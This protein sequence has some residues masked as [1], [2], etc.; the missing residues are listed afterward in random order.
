MTT[1]CDDTR[2]TLGSRHA[3]LWWIR[4]DTLT[5]PAELARCRALLSDDERD[6][7]DRFRFA[8]DRH[9]C[10]VT[11][12]LVRATLSRYCDVPPARWRFR[13]TDHGRPEIA[14]PPSKIRF[15]LSHTKGLIVCLVSLDREVGVDV[16]SLD[17]AT[18]WGD[19]AN[20]F[21]APREAAALRGLEASER[22]IRFLEYWTL[23]ESYIKARGLGLAIPLTGFSFDL[24]VQ[25]PDGIRIRFTPAVDDDAARWQFT[26]A[27]FG[28]DHLVATAVERDGSEPVRI[29]LHEAVVPLA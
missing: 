16:E 12:V 22:P 24:P 10:L 25:S 8:R 14:S 9:A 21:F 2:V 1:A 3:H 23:K 15:N 27:R 29:A 26:L 5:D 6:K 19:L 4:P 11:R 17:R 7:T 20:R 13:T 28:G 18:R